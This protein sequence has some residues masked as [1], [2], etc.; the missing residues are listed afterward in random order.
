MTMKKILKFIFVFAALGV[1][2]ASCST[3]SNGDTASFSINLVDAPGNYDQVN[4]EVV[5]VEVIINDEIVN[6]DVQEGI[7]DLLEL[8]GG[9]SALLAEGELPAGELSQMRLI[10]GDD[11][12]LIIDGD[13]HSLKV[14]SGQ[15]SGLKLNIH[16]TLEPGIRYD[17]I[18]DFNV[19]KSIVVLGNNS[20]YNLKPVIRATT[21]AESGAVSGLVEPASTESLIVASNGT[22][23]ISAYTDETGAFLLYGVP[24]GN[25][26]IT[27]TPAEGS[28]FSSTSVE[29]VGVTKG[30]TTV[31]ET[32]TLDIGS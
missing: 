23:E 9:V 2:F 11:N 3:D 5:G 30:E 20:G 24:E 14:P 1:V 7:Y 12:N 4:I 29:N 15:Q 27:V 21:L 18:L 8:T 6:V 17:F 13:V 25:Y 16:Q 26:T 19:D 22:V 28:N 31:L 10:L 32:I